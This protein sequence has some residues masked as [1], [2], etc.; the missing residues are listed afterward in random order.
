MN[1]NKILKHNEA[2]IL[3]NR[4]FVNGFVIYVS[5]NQFKYI[6][7]CK[8]PNNLHFVKICKKHLLYKNVYNIIFRKISEIIL[9]TQKNKIKKYHKKQLEN[10]L[11]NVFIKDIYYIINSYMI[12]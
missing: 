11:K 7:R 2:N 10:I 9:N 3:N 12:F 8:T 4:I 5:E 6:L 1:D